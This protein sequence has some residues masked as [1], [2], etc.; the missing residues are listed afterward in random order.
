[1]RLKLQIFCLLTKGL[2]L[3]LDPNLLVSSSASQLKLVGM[4]HPMCFTQR[5]SSRFPLQPAC[6]PC[7]P[8]T[9]GSH[10][11]TGPSLV[12][13]YVQVN[14]CHFDEQHNSYRRYFS[15]YCQLP[16]ERSRQTVTALSFMTLLFFSED[17]FQHPQHKS[18]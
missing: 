17:C 12:T 16:S 6:L 13:T 1:M 3:S 9:R 2:V 14:K 11:I 15:N 4:K 10:L 8:T 18:L 5:E 7:Q